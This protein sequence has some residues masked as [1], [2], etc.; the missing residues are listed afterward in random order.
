MFH[1]KHAG[2]SSLDC[3]GIFPLRRRHPNRKHSSGPFQ[4]MPAHVPTND[5]FVIADLFGTRVPDGYQPA[6]LDDLQAC[7]C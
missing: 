7:V 4:D 2:L 6:K 3:R 5:D 1:E